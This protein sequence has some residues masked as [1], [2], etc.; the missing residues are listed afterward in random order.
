MKTKTVL[1][2]SVVKTHAIKIN[3]NNLN[4]QLKR[5]SI[6]AQLKLG[7]AVSIQKHTQTVALP[8]T[9]TTPYI[10][11]PKRNLDVRAETEFR[12]L[13]LEAKLLS[14]QRNILT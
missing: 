6:H 13:S 11:W 10:S 2:E 5:S 9:A 14:D 12:C 4:D 3:Q 8:R 7:S 1:T